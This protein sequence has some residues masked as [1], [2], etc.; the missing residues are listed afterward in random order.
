VRDYISP[1]QINTYLRCPASYYFRYVEG[2]IIPPKVAQTKGKATH[3]GL[4]Y[5]Y[6]QKIITRTD[7]PLSE[8]QEFAAAKFEEMAADTDFGGEDPGKEKDRTVGL[9]K[10]Y[11]EEVAPEIQP[12]AVEQEFLIHVAA[13]SLPV[14]GIIDL[15][16]DQAAIHDTK[17][18]G[19]TP[20]DDEVKK[21]LQLSGYALAYRTSHGQEEKN[22]V[23]DYLVD[24][25]TPKYVRLET[26]RTERDIGRFV[27]V[28]QTVIDNIGKQI[29]YPNP[30]SQICNPRNCGYYERCFNFW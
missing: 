27:Y 16:D 4:E 10:L 19:R 30:V 13:V 11:Q 3:A 2:L 18:T 20:T 22:V 1:S 15:I 26:K 25:K 29:F 6:R 8:V 23:L 7:L 28:A 17:T 9:V 21:S 5:N 12:V 24:T 14:K